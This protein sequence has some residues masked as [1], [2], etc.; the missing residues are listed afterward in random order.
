MPE[1]SDCR[2]LIVDNKTEYAAQVAASLEEIRPSLINYNH[3]RIELT[4][5]A[6]FVAE[7]LRNCPP[8]NPPWNVIISD[9]FMPIPSNPF[10]KA[11]PLA[12]AIETTY[13]YAGRE[14][15]YWEYEYSWNSA[16]SE[17]D[18]GGLQIARTIKQ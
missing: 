17:I 15:P 8:E 10:A 4:N 13:Q 6:Y 1:Q 12:D 7:R 9:V 14:W 16:K 18:H 3:L 5:T 2:V 11:V